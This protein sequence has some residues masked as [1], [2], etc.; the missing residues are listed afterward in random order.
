MQSQIEHD[1]QLSQELAGLRDRLIAETERRAYL[2]G[3][4]D[5]LRRILAEQ[6]A[7]LVTMAAPL[8][9]ELSVP[10]RRSAERVTVQTQD[11]RGQRNLLSASRSMAEDVELS[12]IDPTITMVSLNIIQYNKENGWGRFRNPEWDGLGSFAIPADRKDRLQSKLLNAMSETEVFVQA[13]FVRSLAGVK[14]RI[15]IVEFVD[16]ELLEQGRDPFADE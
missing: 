1:R 15:I 6:D 8:L 11:L 14:Q 5:Q 3:Q 9:R 7:E 2:E 16:I 13:Y 10:M 4:A 12:V